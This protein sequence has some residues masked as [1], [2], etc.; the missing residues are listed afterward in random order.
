MAWLHVR[1]EPLPRSLRWAAFGVLVVFLAAGAGRRIP[2]R[3]LL[4]LGALTLALVAG[5]VSIFG[6]RR[7][8]LPGAAVATVG[9]ALLGNGE[10]SNIGWFAICTLVAACVFSTVLA[11][12]LVYAVGALLLLAAEWLFV[13]DDIGWSAWLAGTAFSVVA[14]LFGRRQRDLVTQLRAAQSDL[15]RRAQDAERSRIARELHDVIAHSLTVSLLHVSSARLALDEEPAEAA[16]ALEE[17]ERLGRQSLDE[18][19]HAVGL[20][21]RDGD[22]DPTAPLP[23]SL[24]VPALLDRFRSAGADV[25]ATV[26]GD[27]AALP[28]TVGLAT[29]RILQEALT[30]AVK[31]A[32]RAPSTVHV[33]VDPDAVRLSVDSA[34]A[35]RT[36]SGL[37]L[38]GMRERAESLGGHCSAGP[39][40]AGWLVRA[41][42]PLEPPR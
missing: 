39:G 36:G 8:V 13:V 7:L 20:L 12:A 29:Y 25:R 18:V 42:L 4:G 19:R 37:G 40:G 11:E 22:R 16:R 10:T 23:G 17:A 14:C 5:A 31:H 15:A 24:D 1:P 30:N 26:D 35:P 21:R 6:G 9:V 27:L 41:E 28:S 34:G 38:V 33:A 32:P 3:P 2:D